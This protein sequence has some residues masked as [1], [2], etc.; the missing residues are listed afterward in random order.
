M[1]P[2]SEVKAKDTMNL[3]AS[4]G[5]TS[6]A[7][8]QL[9]KLVHIDCNFTCLSHM[10]PSGLDFFQFKPSVFKVPS[11]VQLTLIFLH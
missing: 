1:D 6:F 8:V 9:I 7:C 10:M 11:P 5:C 2:V 4:V 3:K